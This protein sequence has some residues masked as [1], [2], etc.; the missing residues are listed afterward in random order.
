MSSTPAAPSQPTSQ[1][2][3]HPDRR[4]AP[5]RLVVAVGVLAASLVATVGGVAIL[6]RRVADLRAAN[7]ELAAQVATVSTRQR[8]A[9]RA[10]AEMSSSTGLMQGELAGLDQDVDDLTTA[11]RDLDAA[12]AEQSERSIDVGAVAK[13]VLRSV[14]VIECPG[15][16]GSGFAVETGTGDTATTTVL[17]NHHVVRGCTD[18]EGIVARRATT[19]FETVLVTWDA[20]H[21]LAQL[22]IDA[23]L[24][25]LT[26]G[27]T[28]EVGDQVVAVGAPLGLEESVTQGIVSKIDGALL[29]TD[30]SINP[31]NSGGP[32]VDRHGEVVGITTMTAADK[33]LGV[34]IEGI[35]WAVRMR[36]ACATVLACA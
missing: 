20:E 14:V 24:P 11:M 3:G 19:T 33:G 27:E 28:P 15:S 8:T 23:D 17:T 6:A 31:G 26:I 29:Q 10:M 30:T 4:A 22:E 7:D 25:R 1:P 35:S 16:L 5:T 21:D 18:G 36:V 34:S 13:R 2:T 32:L 12:F 9:R